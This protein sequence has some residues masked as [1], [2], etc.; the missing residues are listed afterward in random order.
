MSYD[1]YLDL[2]QDL[3]DD[4]Q[5]TL[6]EAEMLA[7]RYDE[8]ADIEAP[9]R[10]EQVQGFDE[11]VD[12]IVLTLLAIWLFAVLRRTVNVSQV[13]LVLSV[14][15]YP[16]RVAT[17]GVVQD[18]FQLATSRLAAQLVNGVISPREWHLAFNEAILVH[19]RAAAYAASGTS[20]ISAETTG[21]YEAAVRR[22]LA[23]AT[24]FADEYMLSVFRG[25]P[26]SEAYV[27]SRSA[28]Y[29][30]AIRELSYRVAEQTF[31]SREGWVVYY[32][33]VD[34]E[35]TCTPCSQAAIDGP[36]LLGQGP[37]PGEVCEGRGK[38]RCL[39]ELVHSPVEYQR[40]INESRTTSAGA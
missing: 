29:A 19:Y 9:L 8:F 31:T 1:E 36:Y 32:I 27:A 4:G 33:A 3:V 13:A 17:F 22:Q 16:Q 10:A 40:L 15:S 25:Q 30:G 35:R 24:R 20:V 34:D 23:F 12:A 6:A 26:W 7:T 11:N 2:L 38:C 5:I 14:L 37:M 39:R 21:L 28:L 18:A